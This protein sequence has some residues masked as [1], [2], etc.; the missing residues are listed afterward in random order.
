MLHHKECSSHDIRIKLSPLLDEEYRTTLGT[1]LA[2]QTADRENRP[3][4][5]ANN[6]ISTDYL[7]ARCVARCSGDKNGNFFHMITLD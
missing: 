1:R 6:I 2:A 7:M 5:T 3:S 4:C